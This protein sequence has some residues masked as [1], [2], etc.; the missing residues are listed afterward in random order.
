MSWTPPP[1]K[2]WPGTSPAHSTRELESRL[3]HLEIRSQDHSEKLSL[4]ERAILGILG[5]LFILSQD[6]LP[7]I[8]DAIREVVLR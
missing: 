7:A 8:A 3:V 2:A 4:H 1:W 5:A 6:R